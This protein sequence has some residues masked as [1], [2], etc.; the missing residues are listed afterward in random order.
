VP[1]TLARVPPAIASTSSLEV[2]HGVA[3]TEVLEQVIDGIFRRQPGPVGGT[4]DQRV[5]LAHYRGQLCQSLV[6]ETT[7]VT[8]HWYEPLRHPLW[9]QAVP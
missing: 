8:W 3:V 4:T 2:V 5:P 1:G 9:A 6:F 7:A